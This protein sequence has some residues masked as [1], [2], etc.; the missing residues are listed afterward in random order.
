MIMDVTVYSSTFF[1]VI[2]EEKKTKMTTNILK[3]AERSCV[4]KIWQKKGSNGAML[5][6]K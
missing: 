5:G 3:C 2:L 4:C 1:L 6:S